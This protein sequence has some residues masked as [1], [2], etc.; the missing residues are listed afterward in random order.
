MDVRILRIGMSG[1]LAYEVHGAF[2]YSIPVYEALMEAG[3]EY[4]IRLYV[5]IMISS[6]KT[7]LKG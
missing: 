3:K 5:L 6:A 7:R 1:A 4:G 2:E